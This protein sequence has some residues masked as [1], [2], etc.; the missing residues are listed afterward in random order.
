MTDVMNYLINFQ[1][2]DR[3]I[4]CL[5]CIVEVLDTNFQQVKEKRSVTIFYLHKAHRRLE[6]FENNAKLTKNRI[7]SKILCLTLLCVCSEQT[8][9]ISNLP[10]K[11]YFAAT[12]NFASVFHL[13]TSRL[14]DLAAIL[15]YLLHQI[16]RTVCRIK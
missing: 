3:A 13:Q 10:T 8:V 2:K 4:S 14:H 15:S 12:A 9:F 1:L 11:T 5:D 16:N 7:N 6:V